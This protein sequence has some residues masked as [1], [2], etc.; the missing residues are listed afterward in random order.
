MRLGR[1]FRALLLLPLLWTC[2]RAVRTYEPLRGFTMHPLPFYA[3]WT[4][5]VQA[6]AR[7]LR[8]GGDSSFVIERVVAP[9]EIAWIAVPTEEVDGMFRWNGRRYN[10]VA[11]YGDTIALSAQQLG[12]RR[13]V[14][15]EV[16]H[17]VVARLTTDTL[18]ELMEPHGTPWGI[19]EYR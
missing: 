1:L 16:L 2:F 8:D 11:F 14:K 6:C 9:D 18:T 5:E 12:S 3:I 4:I 17:L 7:A 10:G 19:C 15:H 13:L